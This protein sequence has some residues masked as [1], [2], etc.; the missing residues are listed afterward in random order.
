MM[1]KHFIIDGDNIHD[2][3]SFYAEIN[4]VFMQGED[5]KLGNSLDAFNDLLYGGFGA[6]QGCDKVKLVWKHTEKSKAALGV[7]TTRKYYEEKLRPESPFNKDHFRKKLA[8]LEVGK[9]ET[10]FDILMEI[11][12][13]HPNVELVTEP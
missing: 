7:E 12:R 8:A 4:R 2:I 1:E 11:I 9:G 10:Y 5:W 6:L 13:E 3:P